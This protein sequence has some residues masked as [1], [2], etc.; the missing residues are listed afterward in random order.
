M[1]HDARMCL[2][3]IVWWG[4]VGLWAAFIFCMSAHTGSDLDDGQGIV[5]TIKRFLSSV[6]APVFGPGVDVV[7]PA[8]HFC[9]YAVFGALLFAALW[10]TS[11]LRRGQQACS[12]DRLWLLVIAAIIAASLYGASDELHQYFVPGRACDPIDWLV[13]TAGA[14]LGAFIV[15][16]VV[17]RSR[18][19]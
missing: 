11:R 6:A 8:A 7:S 1:T 17:R 12:Q 9:E 2:R 19:A 13:D 5:A 10:H 16:L 3:V 14:T 18:Q 15:S 4:C